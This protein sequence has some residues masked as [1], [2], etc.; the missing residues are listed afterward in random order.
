MRPS[1]WSVYCE[2]QVYLTSL[3]TSVLGLGPGAVVTASVPDMHHFSG[4]GAKDV[5]PLWRDAGAT[6]PNITDGLLEALSAQ[7]G[8]DVEPVDLFAYCYALLA[9]PKYVER[10]SQELLEP[11]PRV[12]ITCDGELFRR[13]VEEGKRLIWLHTYG[14][15]LVPAGQAKGTVPQGMARC[16]IGVPTS[17]AGYPREFTYDEVTQTIHVGS[18][19]FAPVSKELWDFK[20][21]GLQVLRSWLAYRSM[22]GAGRTSSSLD[23]MRPD[24]WEAQFTEEF[25]E[26]LWILEATVASLPTLNV[27]LEKVTGSATFSSGDLPAPGIEQ[28]QPPGASAPVQIGL[29]V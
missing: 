18:G 15:R 5:I 22:D 26:T 25:L 19:A 10:F 21:S 1:L 3:L 28:R 4:R 6:I 9:N 23:N 20:V 14:E 2:K 7:Y 29:P 12:P 13:G 8:T 27:L 24:Q 11:G 17:L 16:S